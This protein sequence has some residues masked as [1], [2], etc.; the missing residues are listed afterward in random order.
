M[1][2]KLKYLKR[3]EVPK[4]LQSNPRFKELIDDGEKQIAK[5]QNNSLINLKDLKQK[6]SNK[7]LE[8]LET[9]SSKDNFGSIDDKV[10]ADYKN[11]KLSQNIDYSN[12]DYKKHMDAS[13]LQTNYHEN[14]SEGLLNDDMSNQLR[15]VHHTPLASKKSMQDWSEHDMSKRSKSSRIRLY[16]DLKKV[17]F[18]ECVE[19]EWGPE[20]YDLELTRMHKKIF[21]EIE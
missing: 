10:T 19:K 13:D 6:Y 15:E 20:K 4:Y 5:S 7:K 17:L 14:I 12:I 3:E 16:D 2:K 21:P 8:S 1:E 11:K 9:L 18:K